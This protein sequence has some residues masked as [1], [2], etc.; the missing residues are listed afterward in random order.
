MDWM[1]Q[2]QERG[3]TITSA[4]T[5]CFWH[6]HR[7]NIIDTPGHVDDVDAVKKREDTHR[8]AEANKAFSHYRW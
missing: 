1:E 8:M 2:E 7:I 6:D 5:T 3:I 4:A